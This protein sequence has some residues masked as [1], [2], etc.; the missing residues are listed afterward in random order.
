V[1]SR[2]GSQS[3][4]LVIAECGLSW[5]LDTLEGAHFFIA[6]LRDV[7]TTAWSL[8]ELFSSPPSEA[9]MIAGVLARTAGTLNRVIM[10]VLAAQ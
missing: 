6:E 4:H 1:V 7:H 8:S 3:G 9:T 5:D 2:P 10:A